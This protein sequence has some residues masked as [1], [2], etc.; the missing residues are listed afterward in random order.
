M[1]KFLLLSAALGLAAC[2]NAQTE[3]TTLTELPDMEMDNMEVA[4]DGTPEIV[5]M[6]ETFEVINSSGLPIGTVTI[7]D[8]EIGGITVSL[9]VTAIPEGPHAIHFH[10]TGECG[11]PDF[12]S[13][14]GHYNPT[15]A[16]H[17]FEADS[18]NP[19]AGDMPNI[20]APMSGV[21]QTEVRNE[22]VTLVERAG[23]APLFDENGTAMIIH[24]GSDDYQTQ[25]TGAAGGRIAC[26]V[27]AP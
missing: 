17:G 14:G 22:R 4:Q 1:K 11:L 8:E 13:A 20:T 9:D 7:T 3:E 25:P 5:M 15:D 19:H 21:V 26:A 12:T 23:F 6:S 10:E 18:P 16:N 24:A 2:G 27:I